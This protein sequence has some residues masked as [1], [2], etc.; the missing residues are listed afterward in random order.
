MA[1]ANTQAF[2]NM[3]AITAIKKFYGTGAF[4]I[5]LYEGFCKLQ[6]L[7]AVN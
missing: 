1:V 2:Y 7:P 3:A 4:D 5:K 6:A